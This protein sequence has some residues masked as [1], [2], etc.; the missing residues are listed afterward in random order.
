[1]FPSL[2]V[3]A[4]L[5]VVALSCASLFG[6]AAQSV[7]AAD[8]PAQT[9]VVTASRVPVPAADVVAETTV[10]DRD[11]IERAQ[12]LTL[13]QLLAQQ[14]GLQLSGNGGAG[15]TTSVF[16]RG[17]EARHTLLLVDGMPVDSATVGT[18]SLDNLP[19]ELID[20]IEIVRGPLT[21]LYGSGAMGGVIQL[22]TRRAVQG[23]GASAMVAAGTQHQGQGAAGV[24][25]GDGRF[26]IVANAQRT[27]TAGQS[28]TN[29]DVPFGLYNE[30]ADGFQQNA[31]SLKLGWQ[32]ADGWRLEGLSLDSFGRT[33]LDDGPGADAVAAL[34]N[35]VQRV[36]L[37]G[38]MAPGWTGTLSW[39]ES[40]DE[41]DTEASADPYT[42]LGTVSTRERRLAL[43]QHVDTPIGR[44]LA[45]LE[46]STQTVARPEE[47]FDVSERSINAVALGLTGAAAGHSWQA[48]LRR[49]SNSQ[50]GGVTTGALGWGWAFTPGWRAVVSAGTSH[51]LPSFNQ[52]YYPHFGNPDLQPEKGRHVE[53]GLEWTGAGQTVRA[54]A[55]GNRYR[56]YITSG[57]QPANLPRAVINGYTLAWQAQWQALSVDASLDHTHPHNATEGSAN[58]DK[59]LPRRAQNAARLGLQWQAERWSAG[60][61][62]QAFSHRYDDAANTVRLGGYGVLALD[63]RWM[64]RRDLSLGLRVD[65]VG[66]RHYETALGYDQPHRTALVSLRWAMR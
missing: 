1:M 28:A 59:L 4:R 64:L 29:A 53:G 52:L 61:E 32:I 38:R 26:D 23:L 49:D 17:M 47:P 21:S 8:M 36:A 57:P 40:V 14:P 22:F 48:S 51:T 39:S 60:A 6:A 43:E 31:G 35:R 11:A 16:I 55:F 3:G 27:T 24:S 19:L 44:A 20:H 33:R 15:K 12:G 5:N 50:F 10:I 56:G 34:R 7:L 13:P 62:W 65:N 46:R 9:L 45:L 2:P 18:P 66:D 42:S 41:Y 30:D 25:Y 37:D 58:E 63:A 54:T